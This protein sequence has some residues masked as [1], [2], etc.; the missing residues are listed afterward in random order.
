M[1]SGT[2]NY[3]TIPYMLVFP[4]NCKCRTDADMYQICLDITAAPDLE[5]ILRLLGQT[6]APQIY[7]PSNLKVFFSGCG[8]VSA[9]TSVH[10]YYIVFS[11]Q[12]FDT[13]GWV[14]GV[15]ASGL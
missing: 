14:T 11:V 13:V 6:G 3:Y 8:H 2:L 15:R 12:C 10:L 9:S 7:G 1:S 4:Y 5:V